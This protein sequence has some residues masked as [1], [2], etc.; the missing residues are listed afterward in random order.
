MC[1]PLIFKPIYLVISCMILK[2]P[3]VIKVGSLTVNLTFKYISLL[4]NN[5]GKACKAVNSAKKNLIVKL[6][7]EF[8]YDMFKKYFI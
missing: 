2:I 7:H 6:L 4:D 5:L 3:I 8:K 1:F